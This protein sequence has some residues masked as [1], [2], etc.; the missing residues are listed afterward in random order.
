MKQPEGQWRSNAT[1][2]VEPSAAADTEAVQMG[3]QG[4][5]VWWQ[6]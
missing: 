4:P 5:Q 3:V 6:N 1:W 2:A